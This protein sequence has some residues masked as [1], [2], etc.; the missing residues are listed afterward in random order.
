MINIVKKLIKNFLSL[1]NL[2][3]T[4]LSDF[5]VLNRSISE[6]DPL[7][8]DD[9]K[10]YIKKLRKILVKLILFQPSQFYK[11]LKYIIDNKIHGDLVE[12]GVYKGRMIATMIE[13][14]SF[15]GVKDKKIYLY[16]TFEGMTNNTEFDKHIFENENKDIKLKK[17]DNFCDIDEV[18]DNL[19]NFEYDEDK[20]V[21]V[22]GDVMKTLKENNVPNN[23]SLLRLDTDFYDSSL[24]ELEC[25][26]PKVNMS[27]FI[28]YDDYGHW[29]GQKK[30][31]M[32]ILKREN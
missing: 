8:E 22:K 16:D 29:V 9:F 27:G 11:S 6:L 2:K 30:Q 32:N 19:K 1:F 24:I 4:K 17:G 12:C 26:Y 31:L 10:K 5:V 28:I 20:I 15:Y 18:K 13:T 14:L 7:I 23:I 25:L 3:L 21:F